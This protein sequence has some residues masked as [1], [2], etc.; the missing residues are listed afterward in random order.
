MDKVAEQKAAIR[1]QASAQRR[2]AAAQGQGRAS[3]HLAQALAPYAGAVLAG[4]MPMR[5]EIDPLAAMAAHSGPVAVPVILGRDMPLG[6]RAWTPKAAMQRGA[7]GAL[8][9]ESGDWLV[10]RV[11]IVPLLAFDARGY[12]LGYGGGYYDRSLAQL[13]AQG[14]ITAIGFAYA[15]QQMPAVPIDAFDQKLD[16]IVTEAGVLGPF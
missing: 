2:S 15:A 5:D 8:I 1:A 4:Y 12:R 9:P 10:P 6:F 7:F 11:L 14:P 16:L 13:R 3:A